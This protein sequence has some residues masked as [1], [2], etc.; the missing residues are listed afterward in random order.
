MKNLIK[1]SHNLLI[2]A[3]EELENNE[4]ESSMNSLVIAEGFLSQANL[5][6]SAKETE[7]IIRLLD[8]KDVDNAHKRL[9]RL[10]S[11]LGREFKKE[12]RE[13]EKEK[14]HVKSVSEIICPFCKSNT[15][16]DGNFCCYC[17]KKILKINCPNCK[18]EIEV[19]WKYCPYC[20]R[21][22]N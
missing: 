13:I 7:N 12:E 6:R 5:L 19:E 1:K 9:S 3:K 4:I 11:F 2:L 20:T 15:P 17:G 10:E 16:K 14:P 8:K 18:K 21:V 22:L